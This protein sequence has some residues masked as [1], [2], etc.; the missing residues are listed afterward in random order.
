MSLRWKTLVLALVVAPGAV[1]PSAQSPTLKTAMREKLGNTQQLLEAVITVDYVGMIRSAE[2]LSR[3]S[4]A[5]IASWQDVSRPDYTRQAEVF[6][7]SVKGLQEAA[8]VRN[9]DNATKE[10]TALISSCIQCHSTVRKARV[11]SLTPPAP[12]V[13]GLPPGAT[14]Q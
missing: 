6:L 14:P 9:I 10:Y 4:Y 5:E 3:I 2:R 13:P 8:A 1:G 12:S 11:V 7:L